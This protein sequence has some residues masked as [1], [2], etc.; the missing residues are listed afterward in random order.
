M[1]P[2]KEPKN[3]GIP[4]LP[5]F[6]NRFICTYKL[7][8][9]LYCLKDSGKTWYY[10]LNNSLIKRGWRQLPIDECIFTKN[11]FI[12][13]IYVYDAIIISLSKQNINLKKP[14]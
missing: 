14:H 12:L 8:K 1:K 2:P 10:Y 4:D 11:G 13:V 6:T 9:N 7:I 3:F 5:K